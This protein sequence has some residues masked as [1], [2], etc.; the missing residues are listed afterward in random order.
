M[1]LPAVA[2]AWPYPI[3]NRINMLATGIKTYIG[4]KVFGADA[5][6]HCCLAAAVADGLD[7][8]DVVGPGEQVLAALEQVAEEIGADAVGEH[9]DVHDVRDVA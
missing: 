4:I 9:R 8:N 7:L 2:N 3:E 5:Q 6:V 1:R